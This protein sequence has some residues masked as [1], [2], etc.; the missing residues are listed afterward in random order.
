MTD[1][2]GLLASI[3]RLQPSDLESWIG[4]EL[5][6]T[7]QDGSEIVFTEMECARVRLI[8]TLHYDL[9][10]AADT[11]PLVVSLIDQL[12]DSRQRFASLVTA[13]AQQDPTVRE[14]IFAAARTASS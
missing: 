12:Y 1:I 5:I 14:L 4:A 6:V 10:I 2:Q 11:L 8:C 3:P 7:H 9:E 13:V